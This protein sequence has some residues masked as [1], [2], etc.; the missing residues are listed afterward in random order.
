[1][2]LIVLEVANMKIIKVMVRVMMKTTIV[3]VTGMVEI[4]VVTM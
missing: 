3:D 4:V 2:I 1:M